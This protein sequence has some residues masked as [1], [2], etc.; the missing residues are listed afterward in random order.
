MGMYAEVIQ[1][2]YKALQV[3]T[4]LKAT[5]KFQSGTWLRWVVISSYINLITASSYRINST[6]KQQKIKTEKYKQ[7]KLHSS[8]SRP[9]KAKTHNI[10]MQALVNNL[11][12]AVTETSAIGFTHLSKCHS[13]SLACSLCRSA[14]NPVSLPFLFSQQTTARP[15]SLTVSLCS[16][17][18]TNT[19]LTDRTATAGM[20]WNSRRVD[21]SNS[22]SCLTQTQ[23]RSLCVSALSEG[24]PRVSVTPKKVVITSWVLILDANCDLITTSH[25]RLHTQL[26]ITSEKKHFKETCFHHFVTVFRYQWEHRLHF[27]VER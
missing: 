8:C 22:H 6:I 1:S 26:I 21:K 23:R 13:V 19:E 4:A 24:R 11:L 25:W 10:A 20:I 9:T 2:I 15:L 3:R 7:H 12:C 5:N 14:L 17:T 27:D 16:S 18:S